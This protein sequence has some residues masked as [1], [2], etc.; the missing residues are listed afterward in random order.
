[1]SQE[2]MFVPEDLFDETDGSRLSDTVDSQKFLIF[3]CD[4]LDRKSVV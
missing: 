1:M 3:M 4:N 2:A